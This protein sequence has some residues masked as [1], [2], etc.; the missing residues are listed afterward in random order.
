MRMLLGSWEQL[1]SSGRLF[2][3]WFA[4]RLLEDDDV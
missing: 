3:V 2:V 4:S 1:G